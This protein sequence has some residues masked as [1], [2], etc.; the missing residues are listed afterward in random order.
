MTAN[1]Y[2][3]HKGFAFVPLY[4][5]A[6]YPQSTGRAQEQELGTEKFRQNLAMFRK[7]TAVDRALKKKIT[8]TVEPVFLSPLVD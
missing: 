2:M 8:T 3:D 6:N 4:N 7:Y 1:D 5:S